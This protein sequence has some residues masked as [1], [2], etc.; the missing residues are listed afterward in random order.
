M[1][2]INGKNT[3]TVLIQL[4]L[5]NYINVAQH[6]GNNR[7]QISKMCGKVLYGR[8]GHSA[9]AKIRPC[10]VWNGQDI[11]LYI[12]VQYSTQYDNLHNTMTE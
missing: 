8:T 9:T 3:Y 11:I 5:G 7:I 4:E 2:V 1:Q 6:L 10:M 12:L